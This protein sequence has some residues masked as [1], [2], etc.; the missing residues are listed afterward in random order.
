[1]KSPQGM[2]V[3]RVE[4]NLHG[5]L[6]GGLLWE[7]HF[8]KVLLKHSRREVLNWECVFVNRAK[9]FFLSVYVDDIKM[10]GRTEN[11]KPTW[12]TLMKDVDLEEPISFL[13][14]VF[15]GLYSKR[16]YTKQ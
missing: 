2:F 16:M 9:G 8:E 1:M 6:L 10:A 14:Q 12:K 13:D 7:R 3:N 11:V 4:R 15:F 5:H